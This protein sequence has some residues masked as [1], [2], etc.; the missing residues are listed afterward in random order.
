MLCPCC[1]HIESRITKLQTIKDRAI[2]RFRICLLCG[3]RFI[4]EGFSR[5]RLRLV[6]VKTEDQYFYPG[7][8][9]PDRFSVSP[10]P[11]RLIS[12][13]AGKCSGK[14]NQLNFFLNNPFYE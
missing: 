8:S 14:N 13:G 1:N 7:L 6:M 9:L 11:L 2:L 12:G 10:K 5:E 4:T 3:G